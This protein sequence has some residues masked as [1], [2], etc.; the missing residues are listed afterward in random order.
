MSKA[1]INPEVAALP[2]SGIRKFFD[3]AS[4]IDDCISLGVGEPDFVTPWEIRSAAIRAIQE[5]RTQYT[6]NAGLM[7]LRE[8]IAF[9]LDSRFSARYS[10]ADEIIVTVGASEAID[11]ALR[12][13][14]TRG[15]EVLVPAPSYVSYAPDVRLAGGIPVAVATRA[16]DDFRLTPEA[17]E[18]AITP[19][20][21]TLV[22][23]YPNNPTGAVMRKSDLLKLL[24]VIEKHDLFVISDEIYAEL[25]YGDSRHVSIASLPGMRERT[26]LINGFSKAFAMTGWRLGYLAAPKE[27]VAEIYKIHQYTIMC[28]PTFSQVAGEEALRLGRGDGYAAVEEMRSSYDRRRRYLYGEFNRMG[29]T[30]F[31]PEGAFYVFPSVESTGM[32]GDEFAERLLRAKHI[33]VVPGSAFGVSGKNFV[34]CSYATGLDKLKIAVSRIRE[35]LTEI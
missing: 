4:E 13:L 12:A 2:R 6:S 33:A 18:A 31:K 32:S 21:K 26:V 24:P 20:A 5:G 16:E 35:F 27:I 28:A 9:Y 23:P 22:L 34:R 29:L 10:A 8:E 25:T 11:L 19:R 1:H 3:I 17:L 14:V 30:C 7:S 15:D